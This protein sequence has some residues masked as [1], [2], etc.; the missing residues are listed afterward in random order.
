[1]SPHP[2]HSAYLPRLYALQNKHMDLFSGFY[3]MF[4][5]KI[6]FQ[7]SWKCNLTVRNDWKLLP[8][9]PTAKVFSREEK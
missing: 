7:I 5:P 9:F 1:M 6:L 2:Y 3:G 4:Y 8:F